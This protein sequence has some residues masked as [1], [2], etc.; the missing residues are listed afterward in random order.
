MKL[1]K[2]Q[3]NS[4]RISLLRMQTDG[5]SSRTFQS[6]NVTL[7]SLP[8]GKQPKGGISK[9]I[10]R[11]GHM[12][13]TLSALSCL[14]RL[15]WLWETS[16]HVGDFYAEANKIRSFKNSPLSESKLS[17]ESASFSPIS[18]AS[19]SAASHQIG[20][21]QKM[22]LS[23]PLASLTSDR[24]CSS[25]VFSIS[26]R[27][28]GHPHLVFPQNHLTA[29]HKLYLLAY[30]CLLLRTD[31]PVSTKSSSPV[32][33]LHLWPPLLSRCPPL[34]HLRDTVL[35]AV[36]GESVYVLDHADLASPKVLSEEWVPRNQ[37]RGLEKTQ[38]ELEED[39]PSAVSALEH[40]L[41]SGTPVWVWPFSLI[42]EPCGVS[43]GL[44]DHRLLALTLVESPHTHTPLKSG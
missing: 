29:L 24:Q 27:A 16:S 22:P 20:F 5:V 3:S 15:F 18:H 41:V 10:I 9:P 36:L 37:P 11:G 17:A 21:L 31:R 33:C 39:V 8:G 35:T 43:R 6:V 32:S 13:R 42:S 28:K 23:L 1:H 4:E 2:N 30:R 26:P 25:G 19:H 44:H 38:S 34:S 7:K 14:P 12:T 40:Y